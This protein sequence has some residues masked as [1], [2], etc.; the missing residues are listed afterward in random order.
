MSLRGI[1]KRS[2]LAS[3][4]EN[5]D[6][7]LNINNCYILNYTKYTKKFNLLPEIRVKNS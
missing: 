1:V 2:F 6:I 5:Y 4:K 7:L 3:Y